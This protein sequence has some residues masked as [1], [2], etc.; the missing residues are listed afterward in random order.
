MGELRKRISRLNAVCE[1]LALSAIALSVVSN[2]VRAHGDTGNYMRWYT[3][4]VAGES[5]II[6]G[7]RFVAQVEHG[8]EGNV[9][10]NLGKVELP[11]HY[12]TASPDCDHCHLARNR[13]NTYILV[14]T[15]GE[16]R[17]VGSSCLRDFT[18]HG[19][20]H[21]IAAYLETLTALGEGLGE[22]EYDP[23]RIGHGHT[24]FESHTFLSIVACIIREDGWLGRTKAQEAGC[25]STCD[26]AL[27]AMLQRG[28]S[29]RRPTTVDKSLA[30]VAL[31]WGKAQEGNSEYE[32]NLRVVC[33]S[34]Y[35]TWRN[36]GLL[37]SVIVAYRKA[38]TRTEENQRA[39]ELSE[40]I[41]NVGD[42]VTLSVKVI[43]VIETE[44]H[45]GLTSVI[46]MESGNNSIVWFASGESKLDA[47]KEYQ[48]KGTVKA[49]GLY[50]GVKQTTLTR[51]K[52]IA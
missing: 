44:G 51:C 15:T 13:N 37:A 47:G 18:G 22:D 9:T 8:A 31:N 29:E 11:L 4:E 16:Y 43:R 52:V 6:A 1:K 2:E 20:P 50:N 36:M 14:N 45:Y 17:Q 41:G 10:R 25:A 48:I 3:V 40:H 32:S 28:Q 34:E 12:R 39:A 26:K 33:Q 27:D 24:L 42:K 30:T 38:T 19:D 23:D 5:P 21:A 7:W 46:T 35:C 49:H